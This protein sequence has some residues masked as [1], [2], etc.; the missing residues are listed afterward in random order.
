MRLR[1]RP[2]AAGAAPVAERTV[3]RDAPIPIVVVVVVVVLF[4]EA[5]HAAVTSVA[6]AGAAARV[7]AARALGADVRGDVDL[8]QGIGHRP[9]APYLA[10]ATAPSSALPNTCAAAGSTRSSAAVGQDVLQPAD[11]LGDAGRA[12]GATSATAN[13]S[14]LG[15]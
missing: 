10:T 14:C 6:A 8:I 1:L 15:P 11:A 9:A 13:T 5:A 2:G 12:L 7:H 3:R 4:L